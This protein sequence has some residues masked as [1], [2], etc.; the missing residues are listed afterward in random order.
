MLDFLN[1]LDKQ[2]FLF[3]NGCHSKEFD[4]IMWWLSDKM[5]W[6][7]FYLYL[8]YR[9]VR[10]YGWETIAILLSVAILV[11]L[12]DQISVVIKESV[13]RFRP[14]H[15]PVIEEYVRTLRGYRGGNYGFVSSHAANSFALVYFLYHF[16]K[17]K[18][19]FLGPVL[20][21]WATLVAYSR[22][23]LGVHYPGDIIGGALLGIALA[24]IVVRLYQFVTTRFCI[25]KHC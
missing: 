25:S 15:D 18:H 4:F 11:A 3:L 9:I 12:S 6:I 8:I 24:W 23:Y 19:T 14:S 13:A 16:L 5:I 10:I 2:V 17:L 22:I 7:P 20:I 21:I 1:D